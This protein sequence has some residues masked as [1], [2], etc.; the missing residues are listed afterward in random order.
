[1]TV[2]DVLLFKKG[3][4]RVLCAFRNYIFCTFIYLFFFQF[5]LIF[6]F[7]YLFICLFIYLFCFYCQLMKLTH[8]IV[9]T[10]TYPEHVLIDLEMLYKLSHTRRNIY[11]VSVE[12]RTFFPLFPPFFPPSKHL[13][14]AGNTRGSYQI[15]FPRS[16]EIPPNQLPG[17]KDRC[18]VFIRYLTPP[19]PP[20]PSPP[21]S[22][23][24]HLG[25]KRIVC[26]NSLIIQCYK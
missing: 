8:P 12:L 21:H 11:K 18:Q 20:P 10:Y 2:R 7:I 19:L 26:R 14:K 24:F 3:Q 16:R 23:P 22:L 17:K 25:K 5:D 13:I 15:F 1:M 9:I 4:V 6:L